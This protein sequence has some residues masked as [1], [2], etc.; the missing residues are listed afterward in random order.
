MNN[1]MTEGDELADK[2]DIAQ[3]VIE[4]RLSAV[5]NSIDSIDTKT[6]VTLGFASVIIA[7][8]AGFTEWES[9]TLPLSSKILFGAGLV[10][11]VTLAILS[12]V[13]YTIR[14]WSYRPEPKTLIG[15][16]TDKNCTDSDIRRWV[17]NECQI[18]LTKNLSKLQKK[19]KLTNYVIWAFAIETILLVSGLAVLLFS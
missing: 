2:L 3:Q 5:W 19:A 13:S 8:L 18:A 11:F 16:C 15:H 17:A 14:Q 9:G 6:N 1:E 7:L 4:Q 10:A 12:L